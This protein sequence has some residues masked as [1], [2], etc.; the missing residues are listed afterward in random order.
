M[1][2]ISRHFARSWT[3]STGTPPLE[4]SVCFDELPVCVHVRMCVDVCGYES[5][6]CERRRLGDD[7]IAVTVVLD[8]NEGEV[9]V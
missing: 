3:Q 1:V 7:E 8:E 5:L 2:R 6:C 9:F 4:C